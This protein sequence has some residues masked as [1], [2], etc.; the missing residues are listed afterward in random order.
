MF[1]IYNRFVSV[2]NRLSKSVTHKILAKTKE[3]ALSSKKYNKYLESFTDNSQEKILDIKFDDLPVITPTINSNKSSSNFR[4]TMTSKMKEKFRNGLNMSITS[5]NNNRNNISNKSM[6]NKNTNFF[7]CDFDYSNKDINKNYET[8]KTNIS[9][10]KY[11]LTYESFKKFK[12]KFIRISEGKYKERS[13]IY[14]STKNFNVNTE[15]KSSKKQIFCL[16]DS[17]FSEKK[18]DGDHHKDNELIYD[19]KE[20]FGYKNLYL[21]FLKKELISLNNDETKIDINSNI[22]YNYN[23]TI[24]GKIILQLNSAKIE[25]FDKIND[26]ICCTVDIPFNFL[27]LFYLSTVKQL[28]Y[29]LLNIFKNDFFIKNVQ[30]TNE[31]KQKIFEHILIKQISYKND[32]LIFKNN[33]EEE[34][35]GN[36]LTDYLNYRNIKFR[37]NIKYN[38]MSLNRRKEAKKTI[39]FDNCTFNNYRANIFNLNFN[40]KIYNENVE[41]IK[42][43][44]D[45]NI[46]IIN[47]S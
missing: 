45:S 10:N 5:N 21:D 6:K 15:E 31:Q 3:L 32:I 23:N 25:V 9:T 35:K 42:N 36:I 18:K 13:K 7:I 11:C 29:I 4:K 47:L 24:Y 41:T 37:S 22:S 38:L 20:I 33:F 14:H 17:I 12:K 1:S 16:L 27:C 19:E 40:Q 43:L 28:A 46:N 26:K 8:I 44:F 30:L 2:N 39:K 34:D